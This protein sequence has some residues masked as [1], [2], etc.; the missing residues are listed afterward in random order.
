MLRQASRKDRET[1]HPR[2]TAS[3]AFLLMRSALPA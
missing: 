2:K 1:V 3:A